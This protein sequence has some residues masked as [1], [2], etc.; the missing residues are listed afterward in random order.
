MSLIPNQWPRPEPLRDIKRLGML[1]PER[2][3]ITL[4]LEWHYIS[5]MTQGPGWSG[6]LNNGRVYGTFVAP[7]NS[8]FREMHYDNGGTSLPVMDP[9]WNNFAAGRCPEGFERFSTRYPCHRI[10]NTQYFIT[11]REEGKSRCVRS[12]DA[13]LLDGSGSAKEKYMA[14]SQA[15]HNYDRSEEAK[16]IS[17]VEVRHIKANWFTPGNTGIPTTGLTASG[18][19]TLAGNL[20]YD[21]NWE[22]ARKRPGM[23]LKRHDRLGPLRATFAGR[24][25]MRQAMGMSK[26]EFY[27]EPDLGVDNFPSATG[28]TANYYALGDLFACADTM[29][30][31]RHHNVTNNDQPVGAPL[32]KACLFLT[33][34]RDQDPKNLGY[35]DNVLEPDGVPNISNSC[36]TLHTPKLYFSFYMKYDITFFRDGFHI[37]KSSSDVYTTQPEG[38]LAPVAIGMDDTWNQ[39]DDNPHKIYT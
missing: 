27:N 22:N 38:P 20:G 37:R 26:D 17:N 11:V 1:Y 36:E 28:G 19:E 3:R 24:V 10:H 5:H 23:R 2:V 13:Y 35:S 25:N 34:W 39:T 8:L 31:S 15:P 18:H 12:R 30:Y 9:S 21:S 33:L 14:G 7:L 6:G 4:P 16:W 29:T 32:D